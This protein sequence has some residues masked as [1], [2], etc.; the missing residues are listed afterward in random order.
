MEQVFLQEITDLFNLHKEFKTLVDKKQKHIVKS[1][2]D[3]LSLTDTPSPEE[4]E[5]LYTNYYVDLMLFNA[6]LQLISAKL[7][8][9][10]ELYIKLSFKGLPED[11]LEFYNNHL[12]VFPKQ[13]FVIKNENLEE[14][15]EGLL[16]E[17]RKNFLNSDFYKSLQKIVN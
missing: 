17:K 12:K 14:R 3:L 15:E 1:K 11:I 13:N 6:D 9:Y 5:N 10:I 8:Y 2:E 4:L 16:E 7:G